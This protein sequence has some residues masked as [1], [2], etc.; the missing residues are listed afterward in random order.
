MQTA[1]VEIL[2]QGWLYRL[3]HD[4]EG[5]RLL[6]TSKIHGIY[7]NVWKDTIFCIDKKQLGWGLT[8]SQ[9]WRNQTS[10]R[11]PCYLTYASSHVF[12]PCKIMIPP[13]TSKQKKKET[14]SLLQTK[15]CNAAIFVTFTTPKT[16]HSPNISHPII[17]LP[18]LRKLFLKWPIQPCYR[19]FLRTRRHQLSYQ[20]LSG[21]KNEFQMKPCLIRVLKKMW[22]QLLL[23]WKSLHIETFA[24]NVLLICYGTGLIFTNK[25]QF[26]Y[27]WDPLKTFEEK[28]VE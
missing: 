13:T 10:R 26:G 24:I 5:T 7:E 16:K 22:F 15:H 8:L 19:C 2:L 4:A 28:F 6:F 12:F 14:Q 18:S 9:H 25:L 3:L 20:G 1:V 27:L 21:K 11:I 23:K 17:Q